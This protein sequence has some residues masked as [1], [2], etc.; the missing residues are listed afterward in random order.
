MKAASRFMIPVEI[1]LGW[2]AIVAAAVGGV[3]HGT[4]WAFLHARGENL[5][6]LLLFGTLGMT[7]V[8]VALYEWLSL[9]L[10]EEHEILQAVRLRSVA[11]FT[12]AFA[13]VGADVFV[14]IEGMARSS[15]MFVLTA[16]VASAFAAWAFVENQKVAYALDPRHPT[17]QLQFHR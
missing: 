14:I 15:M 1:M 12:A 2:L 6:W 9:R 17:T 11:C 7:Q 10:A 16:P 13:W 4:L 8:S 5:S 3:G